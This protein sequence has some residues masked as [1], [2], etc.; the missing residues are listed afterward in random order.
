MK[1]YWKDCNIAISLSA[2]GDEVPISTNGKIIGAMQA[3]KFAQNSK[4]ISAENFQRKLNASEY[5]GDSRDPDKLFEG[6]GLMPL[7]NTIIPK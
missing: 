4:G 2:V 6:V 7:L 5:K 1:L 3:F